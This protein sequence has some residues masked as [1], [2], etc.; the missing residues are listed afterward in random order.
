MK[1]AIKCLI[2]R[3]MRA[4][5]LV[6]AHLATE[7]GDRRAAS[8]FYRLVHEYDREIDNLCLERFQKGELK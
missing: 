1:P 2:L 4:V 8:D 5:T 3:V 7:R 6:D